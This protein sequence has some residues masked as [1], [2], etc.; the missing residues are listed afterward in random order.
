M[1]SLKKT[2]SY[3][4][5]N[6]TFLDKLEENSI[7]ACVTDEPYGLKFMGKG[8]DNEVPSALFWSISWHLYC[9]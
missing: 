6:L 2:W 4:E 8:W 5:D 9:L 7:D 3:C 1:I